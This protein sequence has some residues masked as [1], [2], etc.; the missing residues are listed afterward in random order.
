MKKILII[1]LLILIFLCLYTP[2]YKKQDIEL[3]Y[4]SDFKYETAHFVYGLW[5]NGTIPEKFLN[6]MK[7]WEQ[8]GWKVKLWNRYM[9][10][11][12]IDKYPEY[13]H[14]I[15]LFNR[16]VQLADLVRL[17]IIYDEGGHYFDLDCVP[18]KKHNLYEHLN[19]HNPPAVFYVETVISKLHQFL[20]MFYKIRGFVTET[21]IRI[22]NYA[23]G[24]HP[25]HPIIF[26][27]L[28]LLKK[29]CTEKSNFEGDYDILYKTGPDC[30][31][32]AIYMTNIPDKEI[33][34]GSKWLNHLATGTWRKNQDV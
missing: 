31:T 7:M 25:K 11:N 22:A 17:L 5:D 21:N 23:F 4:K 27:N 15:S 6:T 34:S 20:T 33:L 30:T 10:N 32:T 3:Y 13:K 26:E 19:L 2:E 28:K 1:L 16:K 14:V 24:A 12:I 9:V 29:R 8:Q 18:N